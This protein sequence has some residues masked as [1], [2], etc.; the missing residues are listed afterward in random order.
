MIVMLLLRFFH[1]FLGGVSVADGGLLFFEKRSCP[2]PP[3]KF[4]G[5]DILE[6]KE[7]EGKGPSRSALFHGTVSLQVMSG[8]GND[9]G[10]NRVPKSR[11]LTF[12]SGLMPREMKSGQVTPVSKATPKAGNSWEARSAFLP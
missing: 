11:N 10:H 4:K 2:W 8:Q 12:S 5:G 9:R 1:P 3:K 6:R 7:R